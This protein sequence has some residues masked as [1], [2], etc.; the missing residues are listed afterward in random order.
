MPNEKPR[1]GYNWTKHNEQKRKDSEAS[2]DAKSDDVPAPGSDGRADVPGVQPEEGRTPPFGD[3]GGQD[4]GAGGSDYAHKPRTPYP[5]ADIGLTTPIARI[6]HDKD[7][8][9]MVGSYVDAMRKY[10]DKEQ[11]MMPP[12][13]PDDAHQFV[14]MDGIVVWLVPGHRFTVVQFAFV[15]HDGITCQV[16]AT[17]EY[18]DPVDMEK[19]IKRY[20]ENQRRQNLFGASLDVRH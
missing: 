9:D 5:G 20:I 1:N 7:V 14:V 15:T 8:R 6:I 2:D 4:G 13:T 11:Y 17:M 3:A 12:F 16:R 18:G 19:G 10:A